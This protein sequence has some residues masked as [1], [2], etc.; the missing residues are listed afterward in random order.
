MTPGPPERSET[1]QQDHQ[2]PRR[3]RLCGR[4]GRGVADRLVN[5]QRLDDMESDAVGVHVQMAPRPVDAGYRRIWCCHLPTRGIGGRT[6]FGLFVPAAGLSE[7]LRPGGGLV[8]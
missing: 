6:A 1:M 4:N 5:W 8:V 3:G 7:L 2:R